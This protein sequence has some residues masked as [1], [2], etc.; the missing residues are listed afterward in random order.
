MLIPDSFKQAYDSAELTWASVKD[1]ADGI[2]RQI[3]S[4]YPGV[5][6]DSRIKD[7]ES[8]F[9]KA[10]KGDYENPLREMEDFFA[11]TLLLPTLSMIEPIRAEIVHHFNVAELQEKPPDPYLFRYSDLHLVLSLKDTPLRPDKS[12]LEL[13]FELQVKTFLQSAWSQAGHDIIYKPGRISWGVE[14]IAGEIRAL[15]EL[16]DNVLAQIEATAQLLHSQAER[17]Y[18]GYKAGTKRIIEIMEQYWEPL[19][20]PVNRRRMA[21]IVGKYRD[22]AGITTDDLAKVIEE[23]KRANDPIF[24]FLT[25]TPTQKVFVLVFRGY[26]DEV[27]RKLQSG[28][29]RVLITPEMIEFFPELAQLDK[30]R[31]NLCNDMCT[32]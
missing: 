31:V 25:I 32:C 19:D 23:A 15:L 14:R 10:Q 7:L 3:A 28:R 21:E 18:A 22:M 12:V 13:K 26:S 16:A 20:L 27:K 9:V 6:Y 5:N 17:K 29:F 1:E 4:K 30:G 2:L 8:V 11:G 24:D